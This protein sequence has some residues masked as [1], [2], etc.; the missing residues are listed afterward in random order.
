MQKYRDGSKLTVFYAV[1]TVVAA[2]AILVSS[3]MPPLYLTPS[4]PANSGGN[5]HLLAYGTLCVLSYMW[6]HF[7]CKM[8]TPALH[9]ALLTAL[10]GVLIEC[11]QFGVSY[12]SFE[13]SDI[14]VN[15]CAAAIVIIPCHVII[16]YIPLYKKTEVQEATSRLN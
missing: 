16:R 13:L 10:Y 2:L 12:R 6:L 8:R 9:A 14:L 7:A 4:I 1:L 3:I 11:V 5:L 15:S